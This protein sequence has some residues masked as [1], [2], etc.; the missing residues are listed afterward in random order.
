M[1]LYYK[2]FKILIILYQP[3]KKK[4]ARLYKKVW[5]LTKA[6]P[7]NIDHRYYV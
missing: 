3:T 6:M 1:E 4:I 5:I 7:S 2:I